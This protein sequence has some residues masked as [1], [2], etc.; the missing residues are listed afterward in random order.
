[1]LRLRRR[2]RLCLKVIINKFYDKLLLKLEHLDLQSH[3]RARAL[4][5]LMNR[6][7][8]KKLRKLQV[9]ELRNEH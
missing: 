1:M 9:Q 2:L 8:E 7:R 3:T 6:L 4:D 5:M